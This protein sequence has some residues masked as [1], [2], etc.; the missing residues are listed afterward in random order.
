MASENYKLLARFNNV[1]RYLGISKMNHVITIK[2][3]VTL[4]IIYNKL[5]YDYYYDYYALKSDKHIYLLH[6]LSFDDNLKNV[7]KHNH[8]STYMNYAHQNQKTS[9]RY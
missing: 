7:S 6:P 2:R 5:L 8:G 4:L 3:F 1:G 9:T